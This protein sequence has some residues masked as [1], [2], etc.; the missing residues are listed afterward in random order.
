[1]RRQTSAFDLDHLS[2]ALRSSTRTGAPPPL[3]P[4]EIIADWRAEVEARRRMEADRD[5]DRLHP[6]VDLLDVG[7]TMLSRL[8]GK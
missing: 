8:L 7:V 6:Q 3:P 5:D 2:D 4:E 1:L